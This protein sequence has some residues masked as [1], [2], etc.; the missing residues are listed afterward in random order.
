[1]T[2]ED[3]EIHAAEGFYVARTSSDE[4]HVLRDDGMISSPL[5]QLVTIPQSCHHK[6][7]VSY[8]NVT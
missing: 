8:G 5:V 2:V 7:V 4:D 1:M 6:Y 3:A